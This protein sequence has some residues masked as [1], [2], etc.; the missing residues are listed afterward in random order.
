VNN[1]SNGYHISSRIGLFT[2]G[3]QQTPNFGSID[4]EVTIAEISLRCGDDCLA[5]R[6]LKNFLSHDQQPTKQ[7][8]D[9]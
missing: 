3:A 4:T 5:V 7:P 1:A 9:E 8:K 6:A 2:A